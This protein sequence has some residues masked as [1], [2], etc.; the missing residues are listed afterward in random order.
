MPLQETV[1]ELSDGEN[2]GHIKR[3]AEDMANVI[4]SKINGI[5]DEPLDPTKLIPEQRARYAAYQ[6]KL[7]S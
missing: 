6:E 3:C 7:G 1:D 2:A 4:H 5:P